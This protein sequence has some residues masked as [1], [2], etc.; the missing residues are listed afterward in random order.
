[1]TATWNDQPPAQPPTTDVDPC[2][3]WGAPHDHGADHVHAPVP[4]APPVWAQGAPTPPPT[5]PPAT[6]AS[7]R[8][9]AGARAALAGIAM[10]GLL[11]TG[12]AAR[13]LLEDPTVVRVPTPMATP[14]SVNTS[15]DEPVA[16]VADSLGASVVQIKTNE[17]LGSGVVY[18]A[19]GLILTNAHVV[20]SAKSV[21]VHLGDG[22][23]VTGEVLGADPSTDVAVVRIDGVAGLTAAP[24]ASGDPRVGS[25]AVALGSPFGLE[26]SV[27]A[28][29]VSAVNRP[30]DNEQGVV[31]GMIQ[32]D[33]PINPGNSGGAL[34]N[35][36][37]EVIGINTLIFSQSGENNGIGFA[38]PIAKAKDVADRITSGSS[39][40]RAWLGVGADRSSNGNGEP[41]AVVGQ[42][43]SGSPAEQGGLQ[44]GD[45]VTSIGDTTIKG[46]EDL[47]AAI[48]NHN[49]GDTVQ[50]EV[51]RDGRTQTF[52]VQLGTRPAN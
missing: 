36:R 46:F 20:G 9:G 37:G 39:L 26:D 40:D 18:D 14:A 2:V 41:G 31:V 13:G 23:N 30:V 10:V 29:V 33:A 32:T 47:A 38:I 45:R 15:D 8:R 12:F 34:A 28:G 7:P 49:P 52:E 19:S 43:E 22:T 16:A 11:G 42:V 48:G 1:M 35:R 5:V 3:A 50:I 24:L 17:G 6:P 25:L 4:P 44:V 21:Q 27:T 51:Q